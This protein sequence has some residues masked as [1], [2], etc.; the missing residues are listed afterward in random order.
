MGTGSRR[1]A[2]DWF[3]EGYRRDPISSS[4][5]LFIKRKYAALLLLIPILYVH[6]DLF[7]NALTDDAFITLRYVKTLITTGTWGFL[8]GHVVN[9]V[10]SPLNIFLLSLM[11]IFSGPTVQAVLWLSAFV[12][13]GTAFLL[14]EIS[15]QL[16]QTQW[17][18]YAAAVALIVNPLLI[19]TLGL[20]SLL[21]FGLYV[22]C[23]YLYMQRRWSLLAVSLGLLTLTRFD[24]ILF[25]VVSLLLLPD[26]RTAARL[27]T[28]YIMT[29]G[30][31]YL[32]S[33]VY[34]GSVFPDTLFIKTAQHSWGDWQFINGIK[35]YLGAYRLQT[36]LSLVLL[37]LAVLLLNKNIR[38]LKPIQFLL[39]TGLAHFAGYSLLQVPP[40]YWYYTPEVAAILV[41]GC[42]AVGQWVYQS[43]SNLP[44]QQ[45]LGA[46]IGLMLIPVL[47]MSHFVLTKGLSI[48]EMPIHT[49]WATHEQ[50]QKIG[51]WLKENQRQGMIL[52]DGEIGTLGY[53][54]DCQLLSFFS[55]RM[56]LRRYVKQRQ[57]ESGLQAW[58]YRVNFLFFDSNTNPEPSEF[59]LEEIPDGKT[60]S[61]TSLMEWET[62]TQWIPHTLIRLRRQVH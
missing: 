53:Y 4:L 55:D 50:Y 47:G 41:I 26:I 24:G 13:A 30:P 21:F 8:P 49:N 45:A 7:S 51:E 32:F 11:G 31:W 9:A 46:A 56:W 17:I 16:F 61:D 2:P 1:G 39:L 54:C 42:L 57:T 14:G 40:Y 33:W 25:F 12:L 3:F 27:S 15:L 60:K 10:T 59:L 20:E 29:I 35:L 18:G 5:T 43:R 44:L 36:T 28:I 38:S 48:Q 58:L 23:T 6:L 62:S 37:P 34:F 22:L 52:V 19:S